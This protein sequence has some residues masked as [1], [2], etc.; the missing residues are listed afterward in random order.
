MALPPTSN[1]SV[2][3]S[4]AH[5]FLDKPALA[6]ALW[7]LVDNEHEVL[8]DSVHYDLDVGALLQRLSWT[9][10]YTFDVHCEQYVSYV[11]STYGKATI[12]F[13]DDKSDPDTKD[14]THQSVVLTPETVVLL[15]KPN[16]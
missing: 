5:S 8:P 1:M 16:S 15:K 4:I 6:G 10:E 7:K 13:D 12:V 3:S 9:K 2:N 11:T 14:A